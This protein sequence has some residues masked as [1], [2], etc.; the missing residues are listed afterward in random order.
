MK[1]NRSVQTILR[2]KQS[3]VR[4]DEDGCPFLI[5]FLYLLSHKAILAA[6]VSKIMM[7]L[8][9]NVCA[10]MPGFY[11]VEAM[12]IF[13]SLSWLYVGKNARRQSHW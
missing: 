7:M 4:D 10:V 2:P 12:M 11:V 13:Y 8:L 6:T 1:D 9:W 3:V 5:V